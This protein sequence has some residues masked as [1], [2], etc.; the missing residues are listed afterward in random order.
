MDIPIGTTF[1]YI[2]ILFSIKD[3]LLNVYHWCLPAYRIIVFGASG[4]GKTQLIA[5]MRGLKLK[6]QEMTSNVHKH[7]ITLKGRRIILYDAP[8]HKSMQ[9][10]RERLKDMITKE[11]IKGVINVVSYGYAERDG[12]DLSKIFQAGSLSVKD[13]CLRTSRKYEIGQ[14][15]EWVNSINNDNRIKLII[16]Q[17]YDNIINWWHGSTIVR[18]HC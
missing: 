7:K 16:F 9:D 14:L 18:C 2:K 4:T 15:K 11:K 1:K 3:I 6:D 17:I 12:A 8:G 5:Q 13:D 10:L